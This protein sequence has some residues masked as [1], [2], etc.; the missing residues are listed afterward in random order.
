MTHGIAFPILFPIALLG[1]VINYVLETLLL[2]YYYK[3]PPLFD[4]SMN[5]RVLYYL[6][7]APVVMMAFGYW[8]LGNR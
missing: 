5:E 2:A 1:L 7:Y 8:Y 3:Q 6:E 4:N